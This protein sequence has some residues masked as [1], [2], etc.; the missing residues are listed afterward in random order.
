MAIDSGYYLDEDKGL[1]VPLAIR[2]GPSE[3]GAVVYQEGISFGETNVN[4]RAVSKGSVGTKIRYNEESGFIFYP[5]YASGFDDYLNRS[6]VTGYMENG[7]MTPVLITML[8]TIVAKRQGM[9]GTWSVVA[10]GKKTPVGRFLD[11]LAL[12]NNSQ[13][14]ISDFVEEYV[15]ALDVDNRGAIGAQVPIETIEFDKWGEYGMEA[16]P[17]AGQVSG[18][19]DYFMLQMTDGAFNENRGIYT[20]DGL[21]CFPTGVPQYPYYIRKYSDE[22][23]RWLWV[24]ISSDYG[25]QILQKVGGRNQ[26]YPGYGQS[27]TWRLAPYIV[28]HIAIDRMEYEHLAA[29]PPR[30]I[31]WATGLDSPTQFRDQYIA[32]LKDRAENNL[33]YYPGLFQG[34]SRSRDAKITLIHWSEP[35]SGYTP[36][37]WRTE[38]VDNIAASFHMNVAQLEVRTGEGAMTQSDIAS[39]V[40]SET[41]M[42]WIRHKIE[43]VMNYI[44]PPRVLSSVIWRSDRTTRFQ[45]ETAA[46]F[47]SAVER[48]SRAVP[49]GDVVF[50]VEEIRALLQSYIGISIPETGDGEITKDDRRTGEDLSLDKWAIPLGKT[51][52][53]IDENVAPGYHWIVCSDGWSALVRSEDLR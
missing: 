16:V 15:G 48:F 4:R 3:R 29:Q 22:L 41:S 19:E 47:S 34:G 38:F 33:L 6:L 9:A 32:Y 43:Q 14:G 26:M 7:G 10:H 18:R 39:A 23:K 35:P 44:A 51:C 28:K 27:G 52:T 2:T 25:F 50:T 42:A 5:P 30:G 53:I 31:L 12:A 37:E 21:Q 40:E 49:E 45:A 11:L 20:I 36:Q 46:R 1:I 13:V 17:L 8:S 24:L